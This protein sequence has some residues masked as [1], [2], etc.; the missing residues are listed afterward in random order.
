MYSP[1]RRQARS[2]RKATHQVPDPTENVRLFV[3][4]LAQRGVDA[5][6]LD[7]IS[8]RLP[9]N[10]NDPDH[11]GELAFTL[12]RQRNYAASEEVYKTALAIFGTARLWNNYG[13]LLRDWGKLRESI[14]AFQQAIDLDPAYPKPL[15]NKGK[16][17]EML[18]DFT[19]ARACY[20]AALELDPGDV[21]ATNNMGVCLLAEGDRR[22][23]ELWF[24]KTLLLDPNWTD[25]L[26]N[27]AV[28]RLDRGEVEATRPLVEALSRL[29]PDD[30]DVRRLRGRLEAPTGEPLKIT[31]PQAHSLESQLKPA[32]Q[33][34]TEELVGNPRSVFISYAWPDPDTKAFAARLSR[35]LKSRG[36]HV[37]LD[38]ELGLDVA[39]VLVLLPHCQNVVALNDA[40]YAES[41]LLG[42]VPITR[43]TSVYPSFAFPLAA[44]QSSEYMQTVFKISAVAWELAKEI[45]KR[46]GGHLDTFAFQVAQPE[47]FKDVP[48]LRI[49][50]EGW[51]VDEIQMV[52]ANV[53]RFRSLSIAYLGGDHCLAGYPLFDFSNEQYYAVSFEALLKTLDLSLRLTV[54]DAP[55]AFEP[56][57]RT[58]YR[59]KDS[60]IVA[61]KLWKIGESD[62]A[63]WRPSITPSGEHGAVINRF[64]DW[65][66]L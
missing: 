8:E 36:Y 21:V 25:A 37:I 15:I 26:F 43:T 42:K 12:R 10:Y 47:A 64:K 6:M 35:D 24:E 3:R 4:A 65:V 54:D 50:V 2:G 41:C 30:A 55:A 17:L 13:I 20:E 19:A 56:P 46:G 38:Q 5:R 7:L 57:D 58:R 66:P 9:A 60:S 33:R 32:V 40:H 31:P 34:L 63:V 11:W 23:A 44:T 51:R 29:L 18:H 28:L 48:G 45:A 14:G 49:F 1:I 61:A 59:W 53:R 52:F 22:G 62:I 27:L 39:D 16:I